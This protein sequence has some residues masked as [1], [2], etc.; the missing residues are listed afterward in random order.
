[1]NEFP[2]IHFVDRSE[3]LES[4]N[5]AINMWGNFTN[6]D[7]KVDEVDEAK[8]MEKNRKIHGK[9]EEK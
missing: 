1:M 7:L 8:K 2:L 3:V 4:R 6:Y 5:E 9:I